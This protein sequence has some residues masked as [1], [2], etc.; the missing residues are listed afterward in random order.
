MK[1]Y[2]QL[3]VTTFLTFFFF[4]FERDKILY[5][6]IDVVAIALVLLSFYLG[7]IGVI[8]ILKLG[9]TQKLKVRVRLLY[10]HRAGYLVLICKDGADYRGA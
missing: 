5:I 10:H 2:S 1:I 7:Y 3:C 6:I 9:Q 8:L 4:F